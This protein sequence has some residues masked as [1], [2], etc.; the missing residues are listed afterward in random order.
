MYKNITYQNT[1]LFIASIL[2]YAWGG[3]NYTLIIL[4]SIVINY[5]AGVLI[6]KSAKKKLWLTIAVVLNL[7]LLAFFKYSNFLLDNYNLLT[8]VF[9][10]SPVTVQKIV[11]PIGISF[12]TFQGLSYV[13]DVYR[14]SVD[15]QHN[16][17][18]LGAFISL[19]PQL[20]A[21]PIIRYNEI[22]SQL[23]QRKFNITSF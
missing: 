18:K 6:G 9:N 13:V 2:F 23:T 5:F 15:P 11:L 17:I 7:G 14:K 4:S 22:E 20:I 19:F 1:V 10:V 21:G 8:S 16:F 3:V 12:Y